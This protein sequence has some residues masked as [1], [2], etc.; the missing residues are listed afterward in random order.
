MPPRRDSHT[1]APELPDD[2]AIRRHA[3]LW[4][5]AG[6][7]VSF[8]LVAALF[9][10]PHWAD[11]RFY[12]W[13]MSVTRKPS[14]DLA[15]LVQRATWFP[16]LHDTFSRSWPQV[17]L[18]LLGAWQIGAR[19][20]T[21]PVSQRLLLLWVAVGSLEMLVHDVGNERRFVFL[22]PAMAAFTAIALTR[23]SLEFRKPSTAVGWLA[24]P[25]VFYCCYIAAAPLVR[26]LFLSDVRDHVLHETVRLS[27]VAAL[28]GGSL[29]LFLLR[30]HRTV[31][32]F[33]RPAGAAVLLFL[34]LGWDL[35]QFAGWAGGRTYKNY[36][37]MRTLGTAV[38][39]DTP[40]Q[41][42]LANG[43]ALENRIRP[44]FIGHE[45]GNYE[46]RKQR[47]DV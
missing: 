17:L 21:A 7:A 23:R 26:L 6:L 8:A 1:T 3:A 46:D 41:G 28:I 36:Q 14:Y 5:L 29:T 9:V 19:W 13:Q 4:T 47:G 25:L 10:L 32:L 31:E 12:N 11:Y 2:S 34:L 45:F 39:P 38:P 37:A 27:A 30:R 22:L 20:R 43:L 33:M 18:T 42:K 40:I 35:Y 44:I 15:S 24:A 16:V